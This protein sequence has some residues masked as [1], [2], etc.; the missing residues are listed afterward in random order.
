[1]ALQEL[2]LID[3][4]MGSGH[5]LVYAFDVFMQLY[6]A[7]GQSPRTAAELIL[8]N[9]LFGLDIDQRAFQLAYFA[10]M[11]KGR[12]YSRRILSKQ[13]RPNVYAVP[14]NA[15]IGEAELQ[16]V[17]MQFNDQKKA[18]QDLLTLVEGFKNGDELGSLI[19]FEGLDFENL[20]SGLN[21]TNVS[22]FDQSIKEMI[23][24]GELLQQ[25][26]EIGITNPPYM[27]SSG[28]GSVLSKFSKKQ[29]PNSKNDLFAMFMERWNNSISFTGYNTM[30]TMQS[31]MFLSS[32]E[33]MRK[34]ILAKNTITNMMH[35]E[36][37]VMGIAFGTAVTIIKNNYVKGFK[38][39]YHQ[40][41][42]VDVSSNLEPSIIP[43]PGNRFNQ[44]TQDEFSKIPGSPI[45]YWVSEKLLHAFVV[46]K[47]FGD[48]LLSAQGMTTGDNNT[49]LKY[50]YEV[51][52][53]E[54]SFNSDY[55]NM[56]SK[57]YPM[58]KGGEYRKWYGNNDYIIWY[59]QESLELL[60]TKSGF[61]HDGKEYY[62]KESITWSSI[63][64]GSLSMRYRPS[65]SIFSNA[66]REAFN[67]K[68]NY[69]NS[70]NTMLY[71]LAI[72][73]TK[74]GDL[75][76]KILNPTINTPTGDIQKVPIIF[77][78]SI[79]RIVIDFVKDCIGI[80]SKD[81]NSFEVSWDFK[82][83]PLI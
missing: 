43:I 30:V 5:I 69:L 14:N 11:M 79:D 17:Q 83:H 58:N 46:G 31:W 52:V 48:L 29:Y 76:L 80:V 57:W 54:I 32:Y 49:F 38:G 56:T 12:Q 6:E 67:T 59:N 18:Q 81:W 35:M 66:S 8:E 51:K 47:R 4:S 1:F 40:I 72:M 36:N 22:F 73:N 19:K 20:K 16:L 10:L 75:F 82:K 39:T 21:N 55:I 33:V 27:G 60:K 42:T 13:L 63:T 62:L 7:E 24:V 23:L 28:F 9:N 50:W 61:R 37:M 68:I 34:N 2:K 53:N 26:Y 15:E 64:S 65:G 70:K 74:L 77:N 3:P 25:Q 71:V 45:A 78:Q 44:I 41:K